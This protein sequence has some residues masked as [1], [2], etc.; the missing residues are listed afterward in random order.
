[1]HEPITIIGYIHDLP[2][3]EHI[4]TVNIKNDGAGN[5]HIGWNSSYLLEIEEIEHHTIHK[6]KTK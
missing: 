4:L 2:A 1:M 5:S 3:G 6:V